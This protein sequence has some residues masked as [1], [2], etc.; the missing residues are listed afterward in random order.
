MQAADCDLLFV[1]GTLRCGFS[2]HRFL[3]SAGARFVGRGAIDAK[4]LDLGDFPGA[5]PSAR[6]AKPVAG[7]V[8]R[9]ANPD[10]ALR[11]LD[12]VEGAGRVPLEAS[13]FRRELVEVRLDNRQTVQAWVY[14]LNKWPDARYRIASGDYATRS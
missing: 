9:F 6:P 10:R 7:E 14:W 12:K 11:V 1:Y 5:I 3:Q 8:Y 13:L 2:R 4:L